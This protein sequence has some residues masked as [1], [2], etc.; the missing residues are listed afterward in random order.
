[1]AHN[2]HVID[3]MNKD[4]GALYTLEEAKEYYMELAGDW[5]DPYGIPKITK[6]QGIR[7]VR[8]D[9]LVGSKVRGGDCLIS[10][11]S[12]DI[13]T[14]VYV[15]PRTGLAG[16]SILDVAK[17]HNKRVK[18]FMPSSKQISIHQACCIERGADASFHRI[19]AMPNLNLIAK[20]W[21]D[22][23][24]NAFFIPLGLKHEMVTAGIVKTASRIDAPDVVYTATSTGVLTRA[25]QI[26]W[27]KTEFISVCVSRNMKAGE[28]GRANAISEPLA[29]NTSE[30]ADLLPPFPT[31]DTYDGK[32]WKYIPKDSKRDYLF[33]NVGSEPQLNN[34]ELPSLIAS[35]RDWSKNVVE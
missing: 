12:K 28:L 31:I 5:E 32:V 24:P 4:V 21:A 15:Q 34:L 26:A 22:E 19:A 20:K 35:Y 14:I 25:L 10:S 9:Y 2:K 16:V 7:V 11:L 1:L 6:H 33:W 13:D 17:R 23:N 8:D 18:L 29:F 27:P 3:G 30:K